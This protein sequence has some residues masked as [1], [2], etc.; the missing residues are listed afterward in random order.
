MSEL[1]HDLPPRLMLA[2]VTL[3]DAHMLDEKRM[4]LLKTCIVNGQ[5]PVD[6][7]RHMVKL[8]AALREPRTPA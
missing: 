7:A 3:N 8:N 1:L 6:F 4:R 2:A 5:D